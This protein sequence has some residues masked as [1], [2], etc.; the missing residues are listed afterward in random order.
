MG[1][2]IHYTLKS[3]PEDAEQTVHKAAIGPGPAI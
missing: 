3:K 2:T 1:L